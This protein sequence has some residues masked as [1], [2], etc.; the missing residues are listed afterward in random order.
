M[1]P[2]I[3]I[4]SDKLDFILS[5]FSLMSSIDINFI[6]ILFIILVI[7]SLSKKTESP[8]LKFL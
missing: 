8:S 7:L 2:L 1:F 6:F 4:P 3:L 5:I